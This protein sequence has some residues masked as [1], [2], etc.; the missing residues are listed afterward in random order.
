MAA[1]PF[2]SKS[3]T[4]A[5][6]SFCSLQTGAAITSRFLR[7]SSAAIVRTNSSIRGRLSAS[8]SS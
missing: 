2:D 4:A 7:P 8:V 1:A 5:V 6:N 3:F